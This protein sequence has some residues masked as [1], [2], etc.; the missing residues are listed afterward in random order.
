MF[1]PLAGSSYSKRISFLTLRRLASSKVVQIAKT[2]QNGRNLTLARHLRAQR[3]RVGSIAAAKGSAMP[4]KSTTLNNKVGRADLF[5][6][7]LENISP[8]PDWIVQ[9]INR[10]IVRDVKFITRF[11]GTL[12]AYDA[13]TQDGHEVT[14]P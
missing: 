11:P 10:D 4:G 5:I 12:I 14:R 9:I 7:M 1:S 3:C 6:L 2:G 13:G 8:S